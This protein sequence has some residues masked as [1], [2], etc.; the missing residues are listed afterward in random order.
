M[1]LQNLIELVAPAECLGCS[2]QGAPICRECLAALPIWPSCCYFCN[3]STAGGVTCSQ[4]QSVAPLAAVTVATAYD[5]PAKE[6][7][8]QLKFQ[9]SRSAAQV[10]ARLLTARLPVDLAA[11]CITA[12][13]IAPVRYRERGYNQAELIARAVARLSGVPYRSL[14]GRNGAAHQ[15]GRGRH[16][17]LEAIGGAF[18]PTR[19]LRGERVLVIDDVLTTGAT[20]A[21]CARVLELAGAGRIQGAAIARGAVRPRP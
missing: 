10:A 9:R 19:R 2:R 8:L 13:P 21:E 7:V 12:V 14:L 17:R 16:E 1:L 4:C 15:I 5:G 18:Y 11:D 20:L 3:I 6:L